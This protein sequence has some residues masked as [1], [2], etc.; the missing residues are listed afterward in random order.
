[1][2]KFTPSLVH[3]NLNIKQKIKN[4]DLTDRVLITMLAVC[5]PYFVQNGN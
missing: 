1:M 2:R 5:T 4:N 3:K